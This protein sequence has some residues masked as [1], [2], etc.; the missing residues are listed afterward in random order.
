MLRAEQLLVAANADIGAAK[1]LFFPTIS[2]T[3]FLGAS[4]AISATSSKA[5]RAVWSRRR[6]VPADL[7]VPAA[8]AATTRRPRRATSRRSSQYQKSALNAY[9]E[10][11][12]ALVT[13][14]KLA[15]IRVELEKGVEA[16]RDASK[17]SRSR[18]DNGLSTY[19]EVLIADQQ[20]F[21]QELQL[22]QT[23]GAEL[24]AIAELYRALGG[25]W[26]SEAAEASETEPAATEPAAAQP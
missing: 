6:A 18:Y 10:V 12:D 25:G 17:L 8:S 21:Q 19:L 20:L 13:I 2:L 24:R 11:A 14:E 23:R 9:R 3:G 4:A 22:A 5:T 7:P 16:L 1:A 26:Q 15:E